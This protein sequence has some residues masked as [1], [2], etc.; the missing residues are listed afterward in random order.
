MMKI[1]SWKRIDAAIRVFAQ[2]N[3]LAADLSDVAKSELGN[4][5]VA[6]VNLQDFSMTGREAEMKT[7]VTQVQD[8]CERVRVA[9]RPYGR[10]RNP[11]FY[12]AFLAL[13]Y[14]RSA[15]SEP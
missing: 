10:V 8:A 6:I 5:N 2:D 13:I 11:A 4:I 7:G 1:R 3:D 9:A 14:N 15:G 12:Y